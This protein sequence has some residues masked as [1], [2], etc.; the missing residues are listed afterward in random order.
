M[1]ELDKDTLRILKTLQNHAPSFLVGGFLRDSFVGIPPSDIDIATEM[2]ISDVKNIFPQLQGTEKGLEFG[3]GRFTLNGKLYEISTYTEQDFLSSLE[4]RDFVMNSLY[5]DGDR[6][7]DLYG[8]KNDLMEKKIRSLEP[9]DRHF[10]HHPQA[11]LRS[12]RL[13]SQLCFKID[14]DLFSFLQKNPSI[15]FENTENRI[16]QEGYKIL[17]N[18]YPLLAFDYLKKLGFLKNVPEIKEIKNQYIP[19]YSENLPVRLTYF[20]SLIGKEAV[21]EFIDLFLLSNKLKEK[22]HTLIF[23]LDENNYPKNPLILNEIILLKRYL[24]RDDKIK[25]REFMVN[26]RKQ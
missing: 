17:N 7:Y 5:Y 11:Y 6:I 2:P 1:F 26:F 13:S 8:A 19:H 21:Y 16:Q 15:F 9:P 22:L 25:I 14:D 24:Y 10:L 18:L 12:I 20:V 23:Y 3:V 4:N